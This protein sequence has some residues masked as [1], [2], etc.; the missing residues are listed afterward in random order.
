MQRPHVVVLGA[1]ASRQAFPSG[2]ARGRR[3]PVMNDLVEVAGLTTLLKRGPVPYEGRNFEELYSELLI[4]AQGHALAVELEQRIADYFGELALPDGPTLYDHLLLSLRKKDGVAT[5]NWDPMLFL[6]GMRLHQQ[7]PDVKLPYLMFLH[8][9]VAV[10]YCAT[11]RIK[12]FAESACHVCGQ[13]LDPARLLF[14]VVQKDY[15]SDVSIEREWS[16]LRQALRFAFV[17][18]IFGYG[19]PVADVEAVQLMRDAWGLAAQR[20]LEQVE[21]IDVLPEDDLRHRWAAFILEHHYDVTAD[22]YASWL[23]RHP[24]RSCEAVWSQFMEMEFFTPDPVPRQAG[25]GD[26]WAWY[27]RYAAAEP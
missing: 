10:G 18:T 14:P 26:L 25:F 27:D 13:P 1:G 8:G 2:D 3:L 20:E 23:G 21:I 15:T 24:R 4:H 7:R 9:N 16:D 17:L 12:A 22:F 19:A 6:A 5:F 11:H